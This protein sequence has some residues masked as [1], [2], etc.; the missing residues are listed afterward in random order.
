MRHE[1]KQIAMD[2]SLKLR[3]RLVPIMVER[4]SMGL[5]SPQ[6]CKAIAAWISYIQT[7]VKNDTAFGDPLA[8]QLRKI[9]KQSSDVLQG[10]ENIAKV[11]SVPADQ[12]PKVLECLASSMHEFKCT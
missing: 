1:L 6:T 8:D 2:G 12:I 10:G 11:I 7:S 5:T 3:E 9:V 4:A